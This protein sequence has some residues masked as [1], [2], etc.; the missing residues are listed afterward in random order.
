MFIILCKIII[1]INDAK[2]TTSLFELQLEFLLIND[3]GNK[4]YALRKMNEK[5][6]K[7]VLLYI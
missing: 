7:E 5:K 2:E 4:H 6:C 1:R 3:I